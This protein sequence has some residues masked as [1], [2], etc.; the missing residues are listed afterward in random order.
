[1]IDTRK[2]TDRR[3]LGFESFAEVLADAESLAAAERHGALRATGNWQLGQAIGHLAFWANAP[4]DGYPP[5]PRVPW[6]MRFLLK[7]WKNKILDGS[8]PAGMKIPRVPGGT[9]GTE[10]MATDEAIGQLLVALA[11]LE[12]Q[13]PTEPNPAFGLLTHQE[14]IKLN[15][16]HAEL[17]LGFF[18]PE[19]EGG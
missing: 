2:T 14:W 19:G 12:A 3:E 8:M 17:H 7:L 4:F 18:H 11:R 16:R 13:A 9:F 1:M 15:L 5:M 6:F 10:S